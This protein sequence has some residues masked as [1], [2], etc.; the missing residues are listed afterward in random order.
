MKN[1]AILGAS[2]HGK[3]VAD[4]AQLSEQWSNIDFFDDSFP[5][6]K[7]IGPWRVVGNTLDLC[8]KAEVYS[9]VIIG[10]GNNST[11]LD[12][13]CQLKEAG[14]VLATI[15]HPKASVSPLASVGCGVVVMAGA[16]INADAKVGGACI[17]N[18][19]AII[20]HDCILDVGVHLSPGACLAG[21]GRI[22]RCS[23]VGIGSSVKQLITIADDVV[24][25]AGA[26]VVKDILKAGVYVGNP[27]K[28]LI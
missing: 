19:N 24:V 27:A 2:G 16:V 28:Q 17:I 26:V 13:Q 4:A 7:S 23:W 22:G 8:Q 18:S 14:A 1:L 21:G 20:E 10:I 3:V 9:G 5:N 25:G 11:R 12:K 15:V 6:I